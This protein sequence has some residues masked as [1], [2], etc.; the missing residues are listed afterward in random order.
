MT[1]LVNTA[2]FPQGIALLQPTQLFTVNSLTPSPVK[3]HAWPKR[4]SRRCG[5]Y[6]HS[7]LKMHQRLN[8]IL[9]DAELN[10]KDPTN[11]LKYWSDHEIEVFSRIKKEIAE[12]YNNR[13][14]EYTKMI[15][16]EKGIDVPNLVSKTKFKLE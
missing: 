10:K 15:A 4:H 16:E 9:T 14:I 11:F 5:V 2:L 1:K 7:I 12:L 8:A 3:P 6:H 13:Y